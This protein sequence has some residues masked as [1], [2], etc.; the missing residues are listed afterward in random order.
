MNQVTISITSLL[1]Y[2]FGFIIIYCLVYKQYTKEDSESWKKEN[3][4][5]LFVFCALA[6]LGILIIITGF[7]EILLTTKFIFTL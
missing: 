7:I 1:M 3:K 4:L 5:G 2:I 6:S